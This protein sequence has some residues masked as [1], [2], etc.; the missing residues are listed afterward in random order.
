MNEQK[1]AVLFDLD[2]T[3]INSARDVMSGLNEMALKYQQPTTDYASVCGQ[4]S[5][6][7]AGLL[8]LIFPHL[9]PDAD[10]FQALRQELFDICEQY[11]FDSSELYPGIDAL[12]NT[13]ETKHI[14]WGIVTNKVMRLAEPIVKNTPALR[15]TGALVCADSLQHK[16]PH[17]EPLLYACQ[18]LNA[19]PT[20][21]Y[22]IGDGKYD[23]QA[24]RNAGTQFI[25]AL[26]GYPPTDENL[27]QWQAN[28]Y[29][30]QASDILSLL[31][32]KTCA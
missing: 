21:V 3:L 7:S 28:G 27:R 6:G 8:P 18:Q 1:L 13:L 16:K 23:Y 19:S 2:G 10:N 15:R 9:T 25:A 20:D 4:M 12:L 32:I 30:E 5:Y 24:A 22:F 29:A 14:P 31:P 17:P 26:Y 11:I